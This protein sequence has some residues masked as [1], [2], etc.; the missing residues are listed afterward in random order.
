MT[1]HDAVVVAVQLQVA[2]A[3]TVPV[4][5]PPL[6]ERELVESETVD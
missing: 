2:V 1:N 5:I 6:A 3:L 4:E